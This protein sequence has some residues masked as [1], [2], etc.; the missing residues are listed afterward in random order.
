MT[1][2]SVDQALQIA[3]AHHQAGRFEPAAGLY[4]RILEL[5]PD[6]L[7]AQ[8]LLGA[9]YAQIGEPNQAEALLLAVLRVNPGY[10][11]AANNLG[12]L[13]LAWGR[14]ALAEQYYRQA[15]H[16]APDFADAH[17][18]LGN[19]LKQQRQDEAALQHYLRALELQPDYR[20]A[21][22]GALDQAQLLCDWPL[23][24]Q[25]W[26]RLQAALAQGVTG[27]QPFQF[28]ALPT[29]PAQQLRNAQAFVA[30]HY[31]PQPTPA[32]GPAGARLRI[33]YLSCDFHDHA[34]A[35]LL[36][37]VLELHDRSRVE[38]QVF[39]YGA[40]DGGAW[41]RRIVAASDGFTDL[42]GMPSAAAAAAI[43]ATGLDV[44]IDLKGHTEGARLD[45][46]SYRPAPRQ[47]H[48]LGYPGTLGM[49]AVD[50]LIGDPV[51]TPVGCEA[52]YAERILRLPQCYQPNDRTRRI[53]PAPSRAALG[54]P[55]Q[56][57][58]L[59][60]FNQPYKLTADFFAVWLGLLTRFPDTVLWLW[61]RQ[62][63]V[64]QR[65]QQQASAAGVAPQR[66][67]FA[68]T[69]P[70]AEH[71][72]RL[73]QV[74][75]FLDTLPYNAH[76]TASDALWAGCPVLTVQGETFA[77]RVAASLLTAVGLPELITHSLPEYAEKAAALLADS[78]AL[79]ALRRRLE[80]ARHTAPLWDTPALVRALEQ[81]LFAAAGRA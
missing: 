51:V 72:G 55:E 8:Q 52:A 62:P 63:Q 76:T 68:E 80:A 57:R 24:A 7:D 61:V 41:R 14:L 66:V 18:N 10:V 17:H 46:L 78:A 34:T 75:L 48:W 22:A 43:A 6:H 50:G 11:Q 1:E 36:A 19:A 65:L 64:R 47:I 53:A 59:A 37:E 81:L 45:I 77:G 12:N 40:D 4:R 69:L 71:L 56:G 20:H 30:A 44:L 15:L 13:Y 74:D 28:L 2:I 49:A 29:T 3:I 70:L 58:V 42:L 73:Q 38:V 35:Y 32:R 25:L 23:A 27:F 79:P 54:L 16:Y 26:R 9:L 39:S 31:P 21:L 67:L 33:G 60:C 5:V